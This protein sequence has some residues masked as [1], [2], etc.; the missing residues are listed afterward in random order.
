M[1][2]G[3]WQIPEKEL[4]VLGDV[5]GRDILELGCGAAQWSIALAKAGANPVGLDIS[6][7]QLAHARSLMADGRCGVPPRARER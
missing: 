5:R 3:V 7:N 4:G 1:A 6:E 2:W